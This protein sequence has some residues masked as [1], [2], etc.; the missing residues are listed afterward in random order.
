MATP[1]VRRL[2]WIVLFLAV[3]CGKEASIV[4]VVSLAPGAT[5]QATTGTPPPVVVA[6]APPA[7]ST[8][9]A[10]PTPSPS[11]TPKPTVKPTPTPSPT[12]TP[13]PSHPP[14]PKTA[15][16]DAYMRGTNG[17]LKGEITHFNWDTGSGRKVYD[18]A[19]PD[20]IPSLTVKRGEVLQISFTRT[21][22]ET[23]SGARYRTDPSA[24][25]KAT[26]TPIDKKNPATLVA[27]FPTGTVWVDV[28]TYWPEGDVEHTFKLHVT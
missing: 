10:S 22:T 12:P 18:D 26:A 14:T 17:E 8:P 3:G 24:S 2:A 4:P 15:P 23:N 16:P 9:S 7:T 20:P 6:T 21:D 13:F 27:N 1:D 5:P 28:F 25:A 11:A 19:S